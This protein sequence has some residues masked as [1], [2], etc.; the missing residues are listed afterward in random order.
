MTKLID[1]T[2]DEGQLIMVLCNDAGD[3]RTNGHYLHINH[4]RRWREDN[5]NLADGFPDL[6][7]LLNVHF[8][9][10]FCNYSNIHTMGG[11]LKCLEPDNYDSIKND[12]EVWNRLLENGISTFLEKMAGYSTLVS[13]AV[14]A[15]WAKGR[16]QIGNTRFTI[17]T[18]AIADATG[19]P[20]ACDIYYKHSLHVEIQDF[21]APGDRPVKYLSGYTRDSL[22]SPWDRVAE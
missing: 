20:T 4:L 16:V 8:C 10:H 17:S 9:S 1:L 7:K 19:L 12:G 21:N 2:L 15:S 22:P 5:D 13:Y 3:L 18:N 6:S 14:T 11:Q